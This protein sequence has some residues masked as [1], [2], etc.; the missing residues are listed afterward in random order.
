MAC[1]VVLALAGCAELEKMSMWPFGPRSDV[2]PGII[3]PREQTEQIRAMAKTAA[4]AGPDGQ[5]RIAAQLAVQY[6]QEEDPLL[7]AELIR[8]LAVCRTQTA[9]EIL[10]TALADADSDVRVA[11]CRAWGR[12]GGPDS[13]AALSQIL[14]S[15]TDMD[16]RLAAARGLGETGDA[17][18]VA[19]LANAL[20][21]DDP[22][23]QY[24]AVQSLRSVTGRDLGNDVDQWK[25]FVQNHPS[26][27]PPPTVAER[28]R[29][30]F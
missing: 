24:S 9:Q 1:G 14:N 15:D 21:D 6:R 19:A 5:E 28:L 12:R 8:A 16:V 27:A 20:D 11:A 13:V 10:Q 7:R 26:T 23:M 22:A 18:A 3:S 4:H 17:A 29:Q 25:Q 2:V 30:V